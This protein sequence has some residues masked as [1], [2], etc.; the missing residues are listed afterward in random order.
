[1][2]EIITNF[3]SRE[4]MIIEFCHETYLNSRPWTL[5]SDINV[6]TIAGVDNVISAQEGGLHFK[7]RLKDVW[8]LTKTSQK[9]CL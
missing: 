9:I 4:I 5:C 8:K 1:M 3:S 7:D 2:I 6:Q